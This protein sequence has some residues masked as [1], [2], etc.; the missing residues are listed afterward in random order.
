MQLMLVAKRNHIRHAKMLLKQ[1]R[2]L[3]YGTK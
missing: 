1:A 2:D 3:Q